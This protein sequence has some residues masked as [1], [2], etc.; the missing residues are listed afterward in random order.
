MQISY[1][2]LISLKQIRGYTTDHK[3]KAPVSYH[4]LLCFILNQN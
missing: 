3:T 2:F 4:C 1:V